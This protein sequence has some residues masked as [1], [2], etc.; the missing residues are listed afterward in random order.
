MLAR[1]KHMAARPHHMAPIV[2][3]G[4]ARATAYGFLEVLQVPEG[5]FLL[6][7]AAGS[8]LG[9]LL[10]ALAKARG[11]RTINLVRRHAQVQELLDLGY[12][13]VQGIF[14][15]QGRLH[16]QLRLP[17][18]S[19]SWLELRTSTNDSGRTFGLSERRYRSCWTWGR[20]LQQS[21]MLSHEPAL[22][23]EYKKSGQPDYWLTKCRNCWTEWGP[24]RNRAAAPSCH[25]HCHAAAVFP[26]LG[27]GCYSLTT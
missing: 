25:L 27:Q 7:A 5:N 22:A 14:R 6:Q 20:G 24:C 9:R 26:H 12:G 16:A 15:V 4:P 18:M 3:H 11:V 1:R 17:C 23:Q 2:T 13:P 19:Q 8:T 21:R 10:I